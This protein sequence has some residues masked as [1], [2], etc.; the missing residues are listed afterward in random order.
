MSDLTPA[1]RSISA[2]GDWIHRHTPQLVVAG[3]LSALL[4]FFL[5]DRIVYTVGP[6][7]R[8]LKWYRFAGGTGKQAFDEGIRLVAPWDRFYIYDVRFHEMT[9]EV[10]AIMHGG[11]D[12][13]F[14]ISLRYRPLVDELWLLHKEYGPDYERKLIAQEIADAV[15]SVAAGENWEAI[16]DAGAFK[17]GEQQFSRNLVAELRK[18]H[19][20]VSRVAV[21]AI[22]I[23]PLVANAVHQKFQEQ[24]MWESYTYRLLRE[25]AEVKRKR[26]EAFGFAEYARI[27]APA[28]TDRMIAW[29]NIEATLELAKSNN[30]KVIVLGS[31]N[32]G[33]PLVIDHA[34]TAAPAAG[35]PTP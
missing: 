17:R 20:V 5:F 8:G 6:G 3:L 24:Q 2:Y 19:V 11:L 14:R 18:T 34:T 9:A 25:D 4:A 26:L 13:K 21:R 35:R 7:Q 10:T 22:D 32:G 33:V 29:R 27:S 28:L 16:A 31:A 1:D 15:Q 30:A 23:P 12:V